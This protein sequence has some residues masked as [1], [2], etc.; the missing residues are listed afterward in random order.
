MFGKR[1]V[2]REFEEVAL[3]HL[4]ALYAMGL[5]LTRNERDSEDL[6]QDTILKAF[7]FFHR[8]E[9]GT[10][11]K[12]WLFKILTNTFLNR[13]QKGRREGEVVREVETTDHY[14]QF[15]SPD[16]A[17][18]QSPESAL[19]GH[20]MSEDVA[21]ALEGVP[22]DFRMAVLLSDVEEFSYKEIADI[23]EC[24]IGTV[25]SRLYR[26]RRLLQKALYQYAVE[27]GVVRPAELEISD[28]SP[29]ATT[30]RWGEPRDGSAGGRGDG[31]VPPSINGNVPP[32]IDLAAYRRR[33]EHGN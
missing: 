9:K 33:R 5:R 17:H 31:N 19:L 21:R 3:P 25:M 11:C 4:D 14:E 26:G 27:S 28:R 15:V 8:F 16:S 22:A 7:R 2:Q 32:S 24:P 23:M 20:M 13:Y 6:V 1:A 18:L 30:A 29:R 12:A 10:N